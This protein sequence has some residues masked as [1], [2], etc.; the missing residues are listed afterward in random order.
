MS[1]RALHLFVE[2]LVIMLIVFF[3]IPITYLNQ[4]LGAQV[5]L[6][7]PHPLVQPLIVPPYNS[8]NGEVLSRAGGGYVRDKSVGVHI[9][10]E[11]PSSSNTNTPSDA[12][13]DGLS[14]PMSG[15]VEAEDVATGHVEHCQPSY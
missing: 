2:S 12:D 14:F 4:L 8:E 6:T 11:V 10:A 1:R 3:I 13:D 15:I 5:A 9:G 7:P